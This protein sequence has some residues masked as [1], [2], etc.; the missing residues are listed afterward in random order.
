MPDNPSSRQPGVDL[1]AFMTGA[2]GS[3]L[4]PLAAR[5]ATQ[6]ASSPSAQDPALP[7]DVTLRING[8]DK[9]LD[10]DERTTVLDVLREHI[11]L[12]GSKKGCDHG[13]AARAPC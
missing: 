12:T 10:I 5:A 2:A 4:L 11:G 8:E 6:G 13:N 1:R 7:V 9:H 3:A